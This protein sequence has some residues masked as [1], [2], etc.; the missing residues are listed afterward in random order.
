M[1][2]TTGVAQ[3]NDYLVRNCYIVAKEEIQYLEQELAGSIGRNLAAR[4]KA[5]YF[6]N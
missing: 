4:V 1:K 2:C 6:I 5:L 3:E